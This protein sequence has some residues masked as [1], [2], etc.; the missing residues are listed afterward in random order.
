MEL[1]GLESE[2]TGVKT[3]M[4]VMK[5]TIRRKNNTAGNVRKN[6]RNNKHQKQCPT[7]HNK[8]TNVDIVR[9]QG[10]KRHT[11]QS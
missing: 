6:K 9:T 7:T 8:T 3:Q 4:T 5:K 10:T 1:N 2:D 11:A